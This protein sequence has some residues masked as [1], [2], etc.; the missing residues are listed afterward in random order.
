MTKA[1]KVCVI[2][3]GEVHSNLGTACFRRRRTQAQCEQVYFHMASPKCDM[4]ATNSILKTYRSNSNMASSLVSSI[5]L[6]SMP[7]F[8]NVL[9]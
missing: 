9:W 6:M 8:D 1:R 2:W 4:L 3:S 7:G 5:V